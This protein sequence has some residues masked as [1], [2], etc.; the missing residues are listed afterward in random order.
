MLRCFIQEIDRLV[1]TECPASNAADP[2]VVWLD[3]LD[4]TPGEVAQ[5]E[6]YLGI[7]I[8]TRDEMAEI[9]LSDRLYQEN[10]AVYMTM[11]GLSTLEEE[12][13]VKTPISFVLK[14]DRLVT[15]RHKAFLSFRSFA[16]RAQRPGAI[17]VKG[18]ELVMLGLIETIIDRRAD[19]LE[20]VGDEID[21][22]SHEVFR[23]R[24]AQSP[25]GRDLQALIQRIGRKG[26]LLTKVQESL[27][28]LGRVIAFYSAIESVTRKPVKEGRQRAKLIQR[29][30]VALS[31]HTQ[32]L[33]GKINFLLDA[34]LGLIS[35][36]QNQIIKIFSVAAVVML[37]PTLVAS[38][39]GM[40]F[41]FMPELAWE[42]GYPFALG[43][44]VVSA[45]LPYLY[46][47]QRRWL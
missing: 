47:K 34:T 19:T 13:P 17:S 18:G 20:K 39:Y 28:S 31:E 26:D 44:M 37:P 15:V 6:N 9:E 25:A 32:F 4:P 35:L 36:E 30:A 11:T 5:V 8:P 14:D 22:I 16:A 24:G 33:S 38:A 27:V 7:Q 42:W 2:R 45:V 23:A 46:F 3:M 1:E 29:D 21:A 40:N 12:E 41:Q 10:G 43:L